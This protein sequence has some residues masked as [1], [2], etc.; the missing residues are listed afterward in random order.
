VQR[1]YLAHVLV[2]R[3]Y[4]NQVDLVRP[5]LERD[6]RPMTQGARFFELQIFYALALAASEDPT[7]MPGGRRR[8]PFSRNCSRRSRATPGWHI[9]IVH[10]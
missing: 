1:R 3:G 6:F 2:K 7:R 4:R 5:I 10:T 8:E 9:Y